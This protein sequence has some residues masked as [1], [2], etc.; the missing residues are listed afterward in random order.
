M[1]VVGEGRK[2]DLLRM[3]VNLKKNHGTDR[4]KKSGRMKTDIEST[5]TGVTTCATG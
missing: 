5:S 3:R 4:N 1:K 2:V